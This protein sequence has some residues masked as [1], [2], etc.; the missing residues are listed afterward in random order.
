MVY[1]LAVL[2]GVMSLSV[3]S[4]LLFSIFF[5]HYRAWTSLPGQFWMT[6]D[7]KVSESRSSEGAEAS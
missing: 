4:Y 3:L 7:I 2:T 5:S 1:L 6:L